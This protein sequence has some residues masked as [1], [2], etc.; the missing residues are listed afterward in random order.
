MN[1]RHSLD[2]L[3]LPFDDLG[4]GPAVQQ[5]DRLIARAAALGASDIHVE[6]YETSVRIR[7]RLDGVLHLAGVLSG[8]DIAEKRRPQDGR[9]RVDRPHPQPPLDLRVSVL[10]THFGEKVVLR[11]LDRNALRLDLDALG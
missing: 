11:L 8:L 7:Y 4:V 6:P 1:N 3:A 2:D 9:L 10:A 5:V